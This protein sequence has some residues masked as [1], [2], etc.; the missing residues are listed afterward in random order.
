MKNKTKQHYSDVDQGIRGFISREM[1]K[2]N[3]NKKHI[4]TSIHRYEYIQKNK[5]TKKRKW[6]KSDKKMNTVL[7]YTRKKGVYELQVSNKRITYI[8]K[9]MKY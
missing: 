3:S 9:K 2:Y 4:H 7:I 5:K 1:S 6:K 8:Q